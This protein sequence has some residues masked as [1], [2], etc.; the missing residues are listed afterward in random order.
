M[1]EPLRFI[2][3]IPVKPGVE[4]EP[5]TR[6]C[7]EPGCPE[8]GAFRAPLSKRCL[9]QYRWLCLEHVR[10]FNRTWDFFKDMSAAEV[11]RYIRDNAIGHRP[12]WSMGLRSAS[13]RAHAAAMR[14]SAG[15]QDPFQTMGAGPSGQAPRPEPH[16]P[17]RSRLQLEAL[18]T[19]DLDE[20]AT[21]NEVKARYKELVKRYHPDANGGD[22]SSEDRLK[23]V[24]RAYRMLRASN[25]A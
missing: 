3:D 16:K 24:I 22:R 12:T 19:L 5:T 2:R 23:K 13:A 25:L 18:E 7:A 15:F 8:P 6:R 20:D 1:T 21:L 17:Y 4:P 11:E 9:D 10:E 14:F